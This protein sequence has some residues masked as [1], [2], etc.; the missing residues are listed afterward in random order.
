MKTFQKGAG[1]FLLTYPCRYSDVPYD[2]G[3]V[4]PCDGRRHGVR[5]PHCIYSDEYAEEAEMLIRVAMDVERDKWPDYY[6]DYCGIDSEL[7]PVLR[8]VGLQEQ[9]PKGCANAVRMDQPGELWQAIVDYS[10][11][12]GIPQAPEEKGIRFLDRYVTP[13]KP[14]GDNLE[15]SMKRAFEVKYFYGLARPEEYFNAP[16]F[17]QYPEG[18]PPHPSYVAGHGC[19][20]GVANRTF[21]EEFPHAQ[22]KHLEA[23]ELA[24]RQFAH[25]RDLARVHTRQDS[26]E[27][28][29]LGD[30]TV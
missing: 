21:R 29:V 6:F 5:A 18:C 25:F 20:G 26:Y 10:A 2:I 11:R 9:D 3:V 28:W 17:A 14:F 27:G 19:V 24:T 13:N 22:R 15:E 23:V 8:A 7:S 1:D 16:N 12:E 4:N 30:R